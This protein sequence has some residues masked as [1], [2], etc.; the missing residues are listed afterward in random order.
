MICIECVTPEPL[1]K[2]FDTHGQEGACQYCQH[3]GKVIESRVLFE[4]VYDRVRENIARW[5]DLTDFELNMLYECG[6]DE[7]AVA[8]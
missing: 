3:H 6:S 7:I 1:K 5:D 8:S 4:Y 2:L